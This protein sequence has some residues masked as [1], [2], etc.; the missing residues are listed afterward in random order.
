MIKPLLTGVGTLPV[1]RDL[2]SSLLDMAAEVSRQALDDAGLDAA[3]V[4]GLFV[5]PG[6]LS[7]EPWMMWAAN[8]GEFLGLSTRAL[9]MTENGGMTALLALRAAM[10]AVAL[11]RVKAALVVATDTRPR[12]DTEHFE[13]FVRSVTYTSMGLWGGVNGV[14]G[15]GAP[16]P[17]Y[18]MSA[19][20]YMHEYEATEED[21]A[22]VSV[23][24]REHANKH[25]LAQFRDEVTLDDV[26]GS[27]MLSPPI[28]LMQ[29]AGISTG[30]CAIVVTAE[31]LP[32][33]GDRPGVKVSGWGEYHDPSHF[34][35]Q[36]GSIT[37]FKSVQEA[38]SAAFEEAGRSVEDVDVAEVYGVFGATELML[39][40]DL[41]FCAKGKAA[42]FVREGRSTLGGDVLINPTGGRLSFGHPAG[43][44]PLYEVAEIIRQLRGEAPGHQAPDASLGLVHAEH[45]MMNGSIVMLLEN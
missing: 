11:G 2:E 36:T 27:P 32:R 21:V 23:V 7:G 10:D 4:D 12:V 22:G 13:S 25:P 44:T 42:D 15:M 18:A 39:Y 45:G 6:A 35:P 5:T 38:A 40:E 37:R 3:D 8:L 34:I 17:V 28:R 20:R 16:V 14:L 9:M 30:A 29:A 1:T 43:A 33:K 26:L 31:D 41:G 24:L 19:Q